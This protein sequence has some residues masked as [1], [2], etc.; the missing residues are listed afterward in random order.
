M[1]YTVN[2]PI[3]KDQMGITLSHE[4][5]KWETDSSY[6]YK[7]YFDR[8]YDYEKT[9]KVFELLLPVL[10]DLYANSCRTIVETSPPIGGQNIMLLKKLSQK[11]GINIIPC[12]GWNLPKY[13]H[14][15]HSNNF[16]KE[17]AFKWI[18]DFQEGL[19]TID[20]IN[21]KPGY[22]KLLLE[23]GELTTVDQEMLRAAVIASKETGMPIHCH[24]LEAEILYSVI[25]LLEKE[26]FDLFK[27]LWAHACKEGDFDAINYG[28][29]K[30]IWIGFDMIREGNYKNK[31]KLISKTIKQGFED[32][33]LLSQDYDF[34]EQAVELNNPQSCVSFFTKFI[35]YCH[36]NGLPE[37]II[38]KMITE[39]PAN[40]YDF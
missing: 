5:F 27:F 2:G 20:G 7:L 6:A 25:D 18:K 8:D 3:E 33:V 4:H 26:N 38:E 15:I 1:I 11:S 34:Y 24:I 28:Y 40:F 9:N 39:N 36:N 21:I 14:Q 19:D 16:A 17:L 10:E 35:P 13:T 32:K 23:R 12:T 22:I 31:F 30:G 37:N 29:N